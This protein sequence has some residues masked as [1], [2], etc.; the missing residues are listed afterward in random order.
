MLPALKEMIFGDNP[1]V[2]L[3][4]V[5][6]AVGL[7]T[8]CISNMPKLADISE[9]SDLRS[10]RV[11]KFSHCRSLRD[12]EPIGSLDTFSRCGLRIA[13]L[14]NQSGQSRSSSACKSSR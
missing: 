4:G 3:L 5:S 6:E 8:L 2:A 12:L 10:L 1:A 7:K 11:V 14:C 13:P 9:V